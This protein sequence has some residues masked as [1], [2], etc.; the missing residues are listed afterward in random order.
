MPVE[1]TEDFSSNRNDS[2]DK[3]REFFKKR[4]EK[5]EERVYN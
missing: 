4:F 3:I 2:E 5:Q 1:V